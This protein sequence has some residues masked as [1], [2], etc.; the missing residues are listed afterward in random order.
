MTCG[1]DLPEGL[2]ILYRSGIFAIDISIVNFQTCPTHRDDFGV[3]WKRQKRAYRSPS[4]PAKN[5][6]SYAKC[7]R[8]RGIQASTC[9]DFWLIS[10]TFLT[11]AVGKDLDLHKNIKKINNFKMILDL[12]IIPLGPL[13]LL[14]IKIEGR[15]Y[16]HTEM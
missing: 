6:K 15:Y 4:H 7:S 8:Q 2:L 12:L 1:I 10:I 14:N 11:V 16:N 13:P 9:K 3:Y 5:S